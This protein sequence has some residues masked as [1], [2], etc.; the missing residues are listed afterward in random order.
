MAHEKFDTAVVAVFGCYDKRCLQWR[1]EGGGERKRERGGGL[2][3][4]YM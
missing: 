2:S 1:G 3:K 4:V